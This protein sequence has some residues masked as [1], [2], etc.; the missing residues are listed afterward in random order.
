MLSTGAESNHSFC[1]GLFFS[2]SL[3][4]KCCKPI[5]GVKIQAEASS[6]FLLCVLV[7][8][9]QLAALWSLFVALGDT[10]TSITS[11]ESQLLAGV[12]NVFSGIWLIGPPGEGCGL[13]VKV[14]QLWLQPFG[15]IALLHLEI[16][17][18]RLQ[19]T[20]RS[21]GQLLVRQRSHSLW[22]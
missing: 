9:A 18:C 22:S 21:E 11:F 1:C 5:N 7:R 12:E 13:N 17:H 15:Q 16:N 2:L 10:L 19:M 14:K 6:T 4:S 20:M 8:G 3:F